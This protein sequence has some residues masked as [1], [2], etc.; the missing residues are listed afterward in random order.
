MS[1]GAAGISPGET[2][3]TGEA[4]VA[5]IEWVGADAGEGAQ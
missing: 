4:A 5:A 2:A 1:T 3:G